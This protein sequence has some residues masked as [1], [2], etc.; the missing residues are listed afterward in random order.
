MQE[1]DQKIWFIAGPTNIEPKFAKFFSD[2]NINTHISRGRIDILETF[3]VTIDDD[4][5]DIIDKLLNILKSYDDP[6]FLPRITLDKPSEND[7]VLYG[8][9][10]TNYNVSKEEGCDCNTLYQYELLQIP[11]S[12]QCFMKNDRF[13]GDFHIQ[14]NKLILTQEEINVINNKNLDEYNKHGSG[15]CGMID[16]F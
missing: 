12:I 15:C 11:T 6:V 3:C 14:N 13:Y 4:N 10:T 16:F 9:F 2:N 1:Q 8:D 5:I 7:N